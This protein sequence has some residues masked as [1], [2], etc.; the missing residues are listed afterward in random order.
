[1]AVDRV[2]ASL[3]LACELG[4]LTKTNFTYI[5]ANP[6]SRLL[7]SPHVSEKAAVLRIVLEQFEPFVVFRQELDATADA[8]SAATRAKATLDL[9]PHR[10]DVRTTLVGLATYSGALRAGPGGKYERDTIGISASLEELAAGASELAAATLQVRETLT[11]NVANTLSA[12]DI[13]EPLAHALR[14]A[15]GGSARE[16]V[17]NAGN[18]VKSFLIKLATTHTVNIVGATG[19]NSKLDRLDHASAIPKKLV[20]VGK[21]LGHVRNAADHGVDADVGRSWIVQ[22]LT[23]LNYVYVALAF[24]IAVHRHEEDA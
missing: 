24:I 12:A 11:A 17:V 6:M 10:E 4:F 1:M 18:G 13:I 5:V 7:R 16:A 15:S 20:H 14:H 8:S 19:I 22:R 9:E 2:A 21:Y 3:D 23:G